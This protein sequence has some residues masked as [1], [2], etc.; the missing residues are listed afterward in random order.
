[1]KGEDGELG[2]PGAKGDRGLMG[3]PGVPGV[4]ATPTQLFPSDQLS[5]MLNSSAKAIITAIHNGTS[6]NQSH[7]R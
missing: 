2:Q 7:T 1:M 3:P 6:R 4:D 5:M